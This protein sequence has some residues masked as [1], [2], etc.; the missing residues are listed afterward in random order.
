MRKHL[1]NAEI[2]ELSDSLGTMKN[3]ANSSKSKTSAGLFR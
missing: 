1:V 3:G 2:S